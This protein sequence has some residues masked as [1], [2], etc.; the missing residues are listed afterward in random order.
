M[1]NLKRIVPLTILL[2]CSIIG[3]AQKPLLDS[4]RVQIG[5][6]AELELAT[7]GYKDLDK[8]VG[9]DLKSLQAILKDYSDIPKETS[10]SIS[11]KPNQMMSVKPTG[12][13]ERIIWEN[14]GQT[15]YQFNNQ[16]S[17]SS[18]NYYLLIRFN[19]IESLISD[20]LITRI[21]EVI[22]TTSNNHGRFASTYN[23]AFQGEHLVHNKQLDKLN[24]QLD[25][26]SLKGGVGV[27]LIKN[28]P[29][30]DLSAE[31]GLIFSKQGIWKNNYYVSYNQL[32][33][34]TDNSK[35]NLNGFLNAGY[36]YNL[37]NSR[38]NQNWLGLEFGYLVSKHGDLFE[39]NTFK[40]GV[41]WEIGKY[42]SVSP[43][44]YFSGSSTYPAVRIG[45]GF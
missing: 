11:Y 19:E 43:Q 12:P 27:N 31:V 2:L 33:D 1:K 42:I 24:G 41:N 8:N 37:S 17:I 32:S 6:T 4:I 40:L 3:H 5:N 25:A 28:Q 26:L 21:K 35:I 23:Y 36:R 15:R 7:N 44:L 18:D 16:C 39:K 30:M 38:N 9:K 45:F 13:S 22:D 29:V 34:F 14:D 20:E 10:Y